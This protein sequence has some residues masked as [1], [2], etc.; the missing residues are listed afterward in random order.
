[1]TQIAPGYDHRRISAVCVDSLAALLGTQEGVPIVEWQ[2][3]ILDLEQ[4]PSKKKN[5]HQDD[6]RI[7]R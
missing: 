2:V 7:C 4:L 5:G 3:R 1:M 6:D